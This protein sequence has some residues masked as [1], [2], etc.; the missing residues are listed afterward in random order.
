MGC[1]LLKARIVWQIVA[2]RLINKPRHFV[3]GLADKD[4]GVTAKRDKTPQVGRRDSR[5]RNMR[6]EGSNKIN[7][8]Q[9]PTII[10]VPLR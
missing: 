2:S 7:R 3:C 8:L 5:L 4:M 10:N 6:Y 1:P 9:L